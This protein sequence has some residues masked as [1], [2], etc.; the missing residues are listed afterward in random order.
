[1]NYNS[2]GRVQRLTVSAAKAAMEYGKAHPYQRAFTVV[3]VGL[4]PILGLGWM[5]EGLLK[6]IGF[7]PQGPIAGEQGSAAMFTV[8]RG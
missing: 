6:L 8:I 5:T 2:L 3:V 1:M 7:G 4:T